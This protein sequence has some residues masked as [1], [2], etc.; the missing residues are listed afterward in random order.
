MHTHTHTHTCTHTRTHTQTL[1]HSQTQ[2]TGAFT[3]AGAPCCAVG[4]C[5]ICSPAVSWFFGGPFKLCCYMFYERRLSEGSRN[6]EPWS[7]SCCFWDLAH[8]RAGRTYK[9]GAVESFCITLHR[10]VSSCR[11]IYVDFGYFSEHW[12]QANDCS[13]WS[14]FIIYNLGSVSLH[15]FKAESLNQGHHMICTHIGIPSSLH[16]FKGGSLNQGHHMICAHI[17]INHHLCTHSRLNP[18]I[19]G[20]TWFALI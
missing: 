4:P 3:P 9:V 2:H 14:S 20:T 12:K 16:T 18:L 1:R 7:Y 6:V 13:N 10:R 17:G 15:A 11:E 8:H 19:K 5:A